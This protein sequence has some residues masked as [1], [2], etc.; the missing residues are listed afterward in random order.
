MDRRRNWLYFLHVGLEE[1]DSKIVHSIT[2]H[3]LRVSLQTQI[4]IHTSSS[5]VIIA[6]VAACFRLGWCLINSSIALPRF[7]AVSP[8]GS[9]LRL[10]LIAGK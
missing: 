8:I 2:K 9:E 10:R 5:K 1:R 7:E 4:S 6:F 3:I